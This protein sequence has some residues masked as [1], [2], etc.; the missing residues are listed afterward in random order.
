MRKVYPVLFKPD[1]SE[2]LLVQGRKIPTRA[3]LI[4]AAP[5]EG[6]TRN[7]GQVE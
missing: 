3:F 4:T 2:T 1:G 5:S 7:R 6:A